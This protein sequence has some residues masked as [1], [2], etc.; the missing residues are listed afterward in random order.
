MISLLEIADR[1]RSGPKLSEKAWNLSLFQTMQSLVTRFHLEQPE[2][3]VFFHVDPS[4]CD[5]AF[6]AAIQFLVERGV[7]CISSHRVIQFTEDEVYRA[8]RAMP[9]DVII[10][11][12]RETTHI[13]KRELADPRPLQTKLAGHG[14]W[15][16][17][18]LPLPLIVR[19]LAQ[20]SRCAMIEGFN[21][22]RIDGWEVYGAPL[23]AYA[24]KREIALMREGLLKAGRSGTALVYYPISTQAST[25]IAPIDPETGLR[26]SDGILLSTLPDIKVEYGLLTAAIVYEEYGCFRMNGGSFAIVGG[27]CGGPEGAIIESIAKTLAA[28]LIYRDCFQYGGCIRKRME[29]RTYVPTR[30]LDE[31]LFIWPS[32]V[33]NTALSRNTNVIRF[34]GFYGLPPVG[35]LGSPESLIIHGLHAMAN[36]ILGSSVI[37]GGLLP[38]LTEFLL[39]IS[40]ATIRAGLS[41]EDMHQLLQTAATTV[42]PP[43]TASTRQILDRRMVMYSDPAAYFAP[44]QQQYDFVKQRPS[45]TFLENI[46]QAKRYFTQHGLDLNPH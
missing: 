16:E 45:P 17:D 3:E 20:V 44:L 23:E 7:Y 28:W 46:G 1:A 18:L 25:L 34:G 15:S 2:H 22:T 8:I 11:D 35:A 42:T 10:G 33:V 41:I 36:T 40:D 24:A 29:S 32:Y 13:H 30:S 21:F 4:Y 38:P 43:P 9:A 12:G 39:D 19:N 31:E 27:F 6:H 37:S 26:R 5:R 14:P